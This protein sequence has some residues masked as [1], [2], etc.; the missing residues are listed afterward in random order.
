MHSTKLIIVRVETPFRFWFVDCEMLKKSMTVLFNDMEDA[1]KNGG[2]KVDSKNIK[3]GLQIAVKFL[4]F[5]RRGVVVKI[6][7]NEEVKILLVDIARHVIIESSQLHHLLE[8]Y[9]QFP[10]ISYRGVLA[11]VKVHEKAKSWSRDAIDEMK[12]LIGVEQLK[13]SV[14]GLNP[15]DGSYSL[16]FDCNV[17]DFDGKL[18]DFFKF[19]EFAR[20]DDDFSGRLVINDLELR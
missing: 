11:N 15:F 17:N 1:Y 14:V 16:D 20:Q 9:E 10:R 3:I 13:A 6:Q 12:R 8:K 7:S 18:S 19:K 2:H 5:W 4:N